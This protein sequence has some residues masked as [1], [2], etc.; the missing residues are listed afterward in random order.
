MAR[1]RKSL[2]W[3]LGALVIM[4]GLWGCNG[5]NIDDEEVSDSLLIVDS[6]EP[7]TVQSDVSPDTDPN[8]MVMTPP[9]DDVVKVKVRNLNRSQSPTGIFG[10]I[11]INSLDLACNDAL[12]NQFNAPTSVTI[13]AQSSADISIGLLSGA[14]KLANQAT[15]LGI[16]STRC[17]VTFNGQDLSG[18]P[19]LSQEAFFVYSFV[20]IP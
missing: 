18:E 20:D 2:I 14:T 11:Q 16:G 7:A 17:G 10:D 13:P 19:I 12:L 3:S 4:G 15:L 5:T 1:I 6:V 9:D 8:T